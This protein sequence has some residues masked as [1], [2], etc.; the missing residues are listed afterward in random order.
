[1]RQKKPYFADQKNLGLLRYLFDPGLTLHAIYFYIPLDNILKMKI[2]VIREGK[3]PPDKRVTLTPKQCADIQANYDI[4]ITVQPS[5]IRCYSDEEYRE[6]GVPLSDDILDCDILLGVK[7]VP[8]DQLISGKTYFFFSHTIKEQVYNRRLL[9]AVLE[10]GIRLIDWETLT[11]S[12]GQRL[13]AF[14][15]FAGMVGAHNALFTYGMRRRIFKLPRMK[16]CKDYAQAKDHY[17]TLQ[18]PPIKI[19]LTGTGRVANGAAEVLDDMGIRKVST[20]EYLSQSFDEAVYVQLG[21]IDYARHKEG[22][23]FETEEFYNH[24]DRFESAFD[25]YVNT[26]DIFINGIYWD[27]R[28]PV[29]FTLD[30]MRQSSFRISVIADVTCDIA[31]VSSV[32]STIRPSTIEDPVYGFDP[33]LEKETDPFQSHVIDIMAVD[34]LPNELPRD[35]SA[36]FGDQFIDSILPEL[37]KGERSDVLD[38]ASISLEGRL[39]Q[40]FDYLK[41]FVEEIVD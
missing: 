14:G 13:I 4:S 6:V 12:E 35:A 30:Q 37:L 25:P 41:S 15:R 10:K 28:A 27:N 5:D 17:K 38:R 20:S 9:Q 7:E 2:A 32:P 39:T 31:P 40:H 1:M 33:K 29:F 26:S 21:I 19:V 36:S 22:K 18:I 24:P 8:I 3:N 11:N 23:E 16:D 34:N